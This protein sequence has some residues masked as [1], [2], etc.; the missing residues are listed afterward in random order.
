MTRT[1][2]V[3]LRIDCAYVYWRPLANA[4]A[5]PLQFSLLFLRHFIDFIR[6]F[7]IL[8]SY[9]LLFHYV[10]LLKWKNLLFFPRKKNRKFIIDWEKRRCTSRALLVCFHCRISGK[11]NRV[12]KTLSLT[13]ICIWHRDRRLAVL[14]GMIIYWMISQAETRMRM[15]AKLAN[16]CTYKH[17]RKCLYRRNAHNTQIYTM[18]SIHLLYLLSNIYCFG[19]LN[20]DNKL[21]LR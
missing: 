13:D 5:S 15:Y 17:T 3:I 2:H 16:S 21:S 6:S 8:S 7:I 10:T 14:S 19:F 12:R 20:L 4:R 1:M 18:Y 11:A 9:R